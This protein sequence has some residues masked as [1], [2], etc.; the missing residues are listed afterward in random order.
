MSKRDIK[1]TNLTKELIIILMIKS[2]MLTLIWYF[3][4]SHPAAEHINTNQAY[5]DHLLTTTEKDNIHD[6]ST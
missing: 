3:C 5:V 4:F 6:S 1:K 2:V